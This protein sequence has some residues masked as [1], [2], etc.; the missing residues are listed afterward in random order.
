MQ[1]SNV[2]DEQ[3]SYVHDVT[4]F[5]GNPPLISTNNIFL[6]HIFLFFPK[7]ELNYYVQKDK[8]IAVKRELKQRKFQIPINLI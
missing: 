3:V 1:F 2:L 8:I 6:L 7:V 4:F 5:K